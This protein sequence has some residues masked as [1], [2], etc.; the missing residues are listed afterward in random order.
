MARAIRVESDPSAAGVLK[1]AGFTANE[2]AGALKSVSGLSEVAT[3]VTLKGINFE[4]TTI[5]PA[6]QQVY[7]LDL[8]RLAVALKGAGYSAVDTARGLDALFPPDRPRSTE[9]VK[10]QAA[11][12]KKAA[13]STREQAE[14]LKNVYRTSLL[15]AATILYSIGWATNDLVLEFAAVFTAAAF[16]IALT[17]KAIGIPAV[18]VLEALVDV[19]ALTHQA[20]VDAVKAAGYAL[21]EIAQAL[22]DAFG[23]AEDAVKSILEG[24]GFVLGE[25]EDILDDIFF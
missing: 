12:L 16:D 14:A 8:D 17:L 18:E 24:A 11:A 3:A 4:V 1:L 7:S 20:A 19:L 2:I 22:K 6:V 25:I 5:A 21:E 23:L 13:Y 10:D 15:L 9:E